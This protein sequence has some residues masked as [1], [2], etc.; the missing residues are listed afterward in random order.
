MMGV[1]YIWRKAWC[2]LIDNDKLFSSNKI[3][4]SLCL[5]LN[6]SGSLLCK[7]EIRLTGLQNAIILV[8]DLLE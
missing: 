5:I 7:L 2:E 4:F 1:S 8:F 3:F 6:L